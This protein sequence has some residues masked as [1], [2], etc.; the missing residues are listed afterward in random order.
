VSEPGRAPVSPGLC[1]VAAQ[2]PVCRV[3]AQEHSHGTQNRARF[4][5]PTRATLPEN[6][7][8]S[9]S[10]DNSQ[11]SVLPVRWPLLKVTP[12][13]PHNKML[14]TSAALPSRGVG[15]PLLEQCLAYS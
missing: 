4:P 6:L 3:R 8:Y 10:S 5:L 2:V 11:L 14:G 15:I 12:F 13:N 9:Q 7:F 1:V